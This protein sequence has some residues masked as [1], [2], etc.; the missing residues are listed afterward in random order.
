MRGAGLE[1]KMSFEK[2][3]QLAQELAV[4]WGFTLLW[5]CDRYEL[6]STVATFDCVDNCIEWIQEE[7]EDK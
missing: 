1:E 2:K 7:F 3:L 6:I 4:K 5:T